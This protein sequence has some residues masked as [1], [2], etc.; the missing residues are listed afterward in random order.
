MNELNENHW[1]R[2][3]FQAISIMVMLVVL[4]GCLVAPL[5]G[6]WIRRRLVRE[7][8]MDVD[9]ESKVNSD[10]TGVMIMLWLIAAIAWTFVLWCN[11]G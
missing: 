9:W 6:P 5:F 7:Y 3:T 1:V 11:M 2:D 8:A 4:V 10:M